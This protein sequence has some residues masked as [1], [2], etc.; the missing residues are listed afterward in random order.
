MQHP[1]YTL[2]Q[3]TSQ[4][5]RKANYANANDLQLATKFA[6]DLDS[7]SH[8][9]L[10]QALVKPSSE[11]AEKTPTNRLVRALKYAPVVLGQAVG[12]QLNALYNAACHSFGQVRWTEFYEEDA[13]SQ[14]FLPSFANGEGIGPDGCLTHGEVILGLF[15]LGPNTTYPEHAHP[16]EEFYIILTGNPEFKVG[17]KPFLLQAEGAVVLHHSEMNHAIRTSTEPF[18]AIFGW[19]GKITEKSWYRNNMATV[20]EPKKYPTISK[21]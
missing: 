14:S 10:T 4:H 16:A 11:V 15:I 18:Y 20:S 2:A 5:L 9:S 1:L 12:S 19:R 13:W 17:D 3:L 8:T 21:S 6:D 7:V